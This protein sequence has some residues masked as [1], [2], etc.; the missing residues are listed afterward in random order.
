LIPEVA[1]VK[2]M[3]VLGNSDSY[4]DIKNK[5]LENYSSEFS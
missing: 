3:W 4:D 1:L 2:A 5:M